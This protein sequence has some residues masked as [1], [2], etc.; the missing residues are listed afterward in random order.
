MAS[1]ET[2]I[3]FDAR[4]M[5]M[6]PR[7]LWDDERR[8][9]FLLRD[10]A[11]PVFSTDEFVWPPVFRTGQWPG[12]SRAQLD[13]L[14]LWGPERPDWTG[15][16]SPLWKDL[17]AL[18]AELAAKRAAVPRP[19]WVVA[20][21]CF[22]VEEKPAPDAPWPHPGPTAPAALDPSWTSLGFDVSDGSFVSGLANCGYAPPEAKEAAA[23]RW[24]VHLNRHHLFDAFEPAAE[25][26]EDAGAR[27]PEHAPFLVYG[28]YRI[29][30]VT[31]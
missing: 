19:Y 2:L 17:A 25:F 4:K 8:A 29:D 31:D 22:G 27:V 13:A 28:L 7:A 9:N 1:G 23:K 3:G 18:R 6:D 11:G 30:D 12:A 15:L 16:N 10:D 26:A 14:G 24:S 20:V 5:W 21:T